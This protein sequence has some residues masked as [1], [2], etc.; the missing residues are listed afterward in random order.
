MSF[1]TRTMLPAFALAA[2]MSAAQAQTAA[3]QDHN[4][5]H[6]DGATAAQVQP[7]P[8]PAPAPQAQPGMMGG[9]PGMMG[10]MMGSMMGGQGGQPMMGQQGGQPMM[11]Q[12]GGMMP[13]MR[14]MM[15]GQ[16]GAMGLPF[17]HVEGRIAFLRAEL[18]ITDAQAPQWNAFADA[19]RANAKAHRAVHEQMSKGGMPS[20][21]LDRLAAQQRMLGM[22][23]DGV[24]A[25]EAVAKP[26]YAVL[27]DAQ[28]TLADQL[29]SGPM[30]MM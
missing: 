11:G 12:M 3:D 4:A 6:P 30:G 28:K 22:R 7:A 29:L 23:L 17:E 25:L 1:L 9:Q 2:M 27:T 5:H 19:L 20:A 15:M 10:G 24:K 18:K 21:W 26:L 13:M 8:V 14:Q 16:Q